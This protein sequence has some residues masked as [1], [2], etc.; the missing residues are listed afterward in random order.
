M[1]SLLVML[2]AAPTA[3]A[4]TYC[5]ESYKE[6]TLISTLE[7]VDE[8]LANFDLAGARTQLIG[9]HKGVL[10]ID[11][12]VKP[13]HVAKLAR[14][15]TMVFF[16]DQDEAATV[17][18]GHGAQF[19]WAE[20]PWP[21]DV[22]EDHPLREALS[23]EEMLGMAGPADEGK[24]LILPKK[25]A[26]FMNGVLFHE[27]RAPVE[28]PLFVQITDSKGNITRQY[29]QD[30]A[31]FPDDL[32]GPSSAAGSPPKWYKPELADQRI[33]QKSPL[34]G[35]PAVASA[36]GSGDDPDEGT[37]SA[38]VPMPP[39]QP[40]PPP[41]IDISD[42]GPIEVSGTSSAEHYIDP[43]ADAKMR[44]IVKER[45]VRTEGGKTITTEVVTFVEDRGEVKPVNVDDFGAWVAYRPE[46]QQQAAIGSG[47]ADANYLKD[48][49]DGNPPSDPTQPVIWVSWA[50]AKA[51]CDDWSS[52]LAS[53]GA[54]GAQ[55]LDEW[56]ID[57]DKPA[58]RNTSGSASAYSGSTAMT[59]E[60]I[61]FRCVD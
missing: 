27:P 44:A 16:F 22:G 15:L 35:E 1:L 55:S 29:W 34:W 32:I 18:W 40:D 46:W 37:G 21:T 4:Q 3:D 47:K 48:W 19:A 33:A 28:V 54:S 14:Q 25:G 13:S 36:E 53:S 9:A 49:K 38:P 52:G 6:A 23:Y 58:Q 50:A 59:S 30:G 8:S 60:G 5:S 43:F 2:I 57:G 12:L 24:G 39:K 11:T 61:G 10:C 31:A 7:G 56:R 51:Y 45:S 42:V 20:S 26:A 17:R 41:E